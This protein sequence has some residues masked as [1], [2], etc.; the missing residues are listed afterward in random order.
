MVDIVERK[1]VIY[2]DEMGSRT[3]EGEVPD[4][5]K[6][7]IEELRHTLLEAAIEHDDELIEK[8]LER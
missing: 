8:Y 3:S 2:E 5:L 6:D 4:G 1:A 7:T